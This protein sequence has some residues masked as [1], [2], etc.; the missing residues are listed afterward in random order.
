[1]YEIPAIIASV[2]AVIAATWIPKQIE[3]TKQFNAAAENFRSALISSIN[4]ID[5]GQFEFDVIKNDFPAQREVMLRFFQH[6]SGKTRRQFESDWSEYE[7]WYQDVCCRDI[8][9]RMWPEE[10]EKEWR[11]KRSIHPS[12]F[13]NKLIIHAAPK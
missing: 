11:R 12:V 10:G 1:M 8:A 6:L 2:A 3:K 13:M 9:G 7:Q 5:G 4:K